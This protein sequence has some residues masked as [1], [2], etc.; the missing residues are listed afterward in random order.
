[1]IDRI[2]I[3]DHDTDYGVVETR[4]CSTRATFHGASNDISY[5]FPTTLPSV[6][7]QIRFTQA[8]REYRRN[9]NSVMGDELLYLNIP[10]QEQGVSSTSRFGEKQPRNSFGG[11][12]QLRGSSDSSVSGLRGSISSGILSSKIN[13]IFQTHC[14]PIREMSLIVPP[15]RLV[16]P[17]E[18][19]RRQNEICRVMDTDEEIVEIPR[20]TI[21]EGIISCFYF[22]CSLSIL[23]FFSFLKDKDVYSPPFVT[24]NIR[25]IVKHKTSALY[26]M[27]I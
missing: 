18:L 11:E 14:H 17:S 16:Q 7:D 13:D 22:L 23:I 6:L 19:S 26:L 3:Y 15:P 9:G 20:S 25:E 8:S 2:P 27:R 5:F 1:M 4:G 12:K 21:F 10:V 24:S